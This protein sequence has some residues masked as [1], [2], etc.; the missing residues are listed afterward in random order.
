MKQFQVI[1]PV[2]QTKSIFLVCIRSLFQTINYSTELIII[3]DGSD[4]NCIS[5]IQENLEMPKNLQVRY[6]EHSVSIGCP[7]S[8]NQGMEFINKNSYVIFADSDIVFAPKWQETVIETLNDSSIGAVSGIFLYP[9]SGG[10]QCCGIAYQNFLARHIYLNNNLRNLTLKPVFDVQATIFAFFATKGKIV[11][12]CGRLDECFFNGYEDIDY[13]LRMRKDGYRIVTNTA[14][15]FY[16]FEKSNGIHRHFSRKQNLGLFWAKHASHVKNDLYRY[17][18]RQLTT[19]D[20]AP[21]K[22]VL[23]NMC[24][25]QMD[26]IEMIKYLKQNILI[27]S[28]HDVS[29]FCNIDRKLWLPELLSSDSYALPKPYIFLCDNFVE[30]TENSYWFSLR[31][32]YSKVDI[33]IDLYANVIPFCSLVSS[34]WPGNKIR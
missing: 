4:F 3:N 28:V 20:F 24:E 16:H 12:E 1:M 11:K 6:I 17:L 31:S 8:I 34:F 23:I 21:Q 30:L 15:T 7:K 33:I 19:Y 26:S 25:A 9:Q 29:S 27:D 14:M 22:Y 5:V 2:F 32:K 18:E 13:Q 10:I